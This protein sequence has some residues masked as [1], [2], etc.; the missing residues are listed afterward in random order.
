MKRDLVASIRN[1][2]SREV[3]VHQRYI[4]SARRAGAL[5]VRIVEELPE[6]YFEDVR[7]GIEAIGEEIYFWSPSKEGNETLH[8]LAHEI[9]RLLGVK[10]DKQ[11]QEWN[12]SFLYR[13]KVGTTRIEIR[14]VKFFGK[15]KVVREETVEKT[16]RYRLV[17]K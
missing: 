16:V 9:A 1:E 10:F 6:H 11:F 17:C 12:G 4:E 8:K 3:A 7:I 13:G 5:A 2:V 14:G 15:C